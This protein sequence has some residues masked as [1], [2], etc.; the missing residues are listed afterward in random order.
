MN[1]EDTAA[2]PSAKPRRRPKALLDGP[3][4]DD[5]RDLVKGDGQKAARRREV[6]ARSLVTFA[7][8]TGTHLGTEHAAR[9]RRKTSRAGP[10]TAPSTSSARRGH[11]RPSLAF[12]GRDEAVLGGVSTRRPTPCSVLGHDLEEEARR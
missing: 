5:L 1:R 3:D 11:A 6:L 9:A 2:T 7:P 12:T 10:S 4:P 8:A